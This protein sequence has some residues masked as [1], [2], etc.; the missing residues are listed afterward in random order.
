MAKRSRSRKL[1]QPLGI[2]STAT[3]SSYQDGN[4]TPRRIR[5]SGID[6]RWLIRS[7]SV[8]AEAVSSTTEEAIPPTSTHAGS[9]GQGACDR[10]CVNPA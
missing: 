2:P 5:A 10:L 8:A 1:W 4:R 7:R 9:L 3:S 6:L